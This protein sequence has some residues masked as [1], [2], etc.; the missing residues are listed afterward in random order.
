M[1]RQI[2]SADRTTSGSAGSDWGCLKDPA[3]NFGGEG[4]F[5]SIS[6]N[7][8]PWRRLKGRYV[9]SMLRVQIQSYLFQYYVKD[10]LGFP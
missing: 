10:T 8:L 1:V 6:G 2:P 3:P 4:L 5:Q 9:V 7:T